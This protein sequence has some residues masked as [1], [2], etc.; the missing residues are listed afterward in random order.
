MT[1]IKKEKTKIETD[2]TV[3]QLP[4]ISKTSLKT[5]IYK[6]KARLSYL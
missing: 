1:S 3:V 4:N 5:T 6:E 2:F